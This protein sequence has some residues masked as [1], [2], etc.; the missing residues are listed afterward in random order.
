MNCLRVLPCFLLLCL[1]TAAQPVEPEAIYRIQPAE[2]SAR[3]TSVDASGDDLLFS[4]SSRTA[5]ELV[6][7]DHSGRELRR[8]TTP[9][10]SREALLAPN[11]RT[12]MLRRAGSGL[13]EVSTDC[14]VLRQTN[15]PQKTIRILVDQNV[16]LGVSGENLFPLDLIALQPGSTIPYKI[17]GDDPA[18]FVRPSPGSI[19]VVYI[20][21]GRVAFLS[22]A[23]KGQRVHQCLDA[24]VLKRSRELD[25]YEA[26]FAPA[27][28]SRAGR[29]LL[30]LSGFKARE[31]APLYSLGPDGDCTRLG[32]LRVPEIAELAVAPR[33]DRRF[34]NPH[35]E[36]SFDAV[37]STTVALHLIDRGSGFVARYPVNHFH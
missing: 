3:L 25:A 37:V 31:G 4:F 7:T 13:T 22:T 28:G 27:V 11:G 18:Y 33:A 5:T 15:F 14:R 24:A 9:G 36:L 2:P 30:F 23:S 35:G 10:A 32:L 16:V 21:T 26:L 6:R 12:I 19:A 34:S 1:A 8:C 20:G 17:L 29:V